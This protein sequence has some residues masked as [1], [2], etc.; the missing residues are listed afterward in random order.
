MLTLERAMTEY[1]KL[2][3]PEFS[4]NNAD[5]LPIFAASAVAL[6]SQMSVKRYI[7]IPATFYIALIGEPRS[8]K[9]SFFN[10]FLRLFRGTHV[11]EI[12]I[13]SPEAMLKAIKEI[14]HGYI[15]YDEVSH[16]AKLLDSYMGTLLPILNKM[17]YLDG[18]SQIRVDN[19]KSVIVEPESYFVHVFFGGTPADWSVIERKAVG[20]FVRRTLV[21]YV[22][23]QIPFFSEPE[24]S[25]EE[26]KRRAQLSNL[27]NATLKALTHIRLTVRV[28]GLTSLAEQLSK[29][30][31]D[32]EKKSMIEEYMY[33]IIAGRLVANLITLDINEKPRDITADV[34]K[35]RIK[36]NAERYGI[37]CE[38]WGT[39]GD[40]YEMYLEYDAT[41]VDA[42][43][44]GSDVK[45][46]D[47]L[48]PHFARV[49]FEQL[50]RSVRPQLSAPDQ[51]TM[52]NV[53]RIRQW[54][55]AGGSVVVSMTKFG[56]EILHVGNPQFYK[57]VIEILQAA[58]YIRV[59]EYQRK[60]KLAQYVILDPKARIC[61]NCAFYRSL[62]KCPK[63]EGI[64]DFKEAAEKVPP[65][66][67]A[68]E[69]FEEVGE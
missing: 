59:V 1:F 54:L 28:K 36:Q 15:Y 56:R 12:P 67:D 50:V 5:I 69:K 65:W 35:K 39:T 26:E 8:G 60:G 14:R 24:I 45:I 51:I 34:I 6:A 68:C 44:K 58:G 41:D 23:G 4:Q 11:G 38:D 30:F 66:A 13:G 46:T 10:A 2:S 31:L 22:K 9:T 37:K 7:T 57:P 61:G 18:L 29:E 55:E 19:K 43:N 32:N 48:P 20:G 33:K 62:D 42:D 16:L 17:Y 25:I 40:Y 27:I 47:Y 49:T 53:E 52:R 64:F 3:R 21:L 63:L